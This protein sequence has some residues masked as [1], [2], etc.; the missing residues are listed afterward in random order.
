MVIFKV[1]LYL[2][3]FRPT[4]SSLQISCQWHAS[5]TLVQFC[6]LWAVNNLNKF[7]LKCVE[8]AVSALKNARASKG[9]TPRPLHPTR[10]KACGRYALQFFALC[11]N[12]SLCREETNM[13]VACVMT[14]TIGLI[15]RHMKTIYGAPSR[16][17]PTGTLKQSYATDPIV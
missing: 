17:L 11:A 6:Q 7:A 3:L 14:C 4:A 2:Q 13:A 1:G 12:T 5:N 10:R 9:F 16:P 8:N 15:R